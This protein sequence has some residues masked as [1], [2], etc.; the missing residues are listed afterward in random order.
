[1]LEKLEARA[2]ALYEAYAH[3]VSWVAHDGTNLPTWPDVAER[4]KEAWR[5]V[6]QHVEDAPKDVAAP[7][8]NASE[9]LAD[10]LK[11]DPEVKTEDAKGGE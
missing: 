1:M 8:V 2:K 11:S 4:T 10:A 9:V 3:E 6:A 5:A 7:A